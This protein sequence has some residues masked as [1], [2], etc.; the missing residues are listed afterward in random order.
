L[1]A[2]YFLKCW[3]FYASELTVCTHLDDGKLFASF[4]RKMLRDYFE[5]SGTITAYTAAEIA[6][7]L[8]L[9]DLMNFSD[10]QKSLVILL[11]LSV[12]ANY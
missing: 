4:L 6:L 9:E 10:S 7:L 1:G 2:L 11:L 5:R 8:L 3:R 12:Q